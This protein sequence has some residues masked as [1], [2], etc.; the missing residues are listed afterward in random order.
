MEYNILA[1]NPGS[2]S[3]KAGWFRNLEPVKTIS[4]SHT[5]EEL[6]RHEGV[7]GQLEFRTQLILEALQEASLDVKS[8]DAVIGRGG[9][10]RP[11]ASGVYTV[12]QAM[13]E[14]LQAERH[15]R[16]ASNLG[17]LIARR[18]AVSAGV[19][20]YIAD[21]VVVD[22]LDEVARISGHPLL[23]RISIFHALNQKAMARRYAASVGR[24]YAELNLIVAHLG[25]GVSV[26][27]HRD[28]RVVDVN[29]ALDGEGPFSPERAGTLPWGRLAELCFSGEYT[30]PQ[31]QRMLCGQGGLVAHTGTN[32][33]RAILA[34]A[35]AGD[36]ESALLTEAFCYNV[37]KSIAALSALFSGRVDA[38]ILTG[39][40]AHSRQICQAIS[41]RVD[42]IAP[43]AILPGENEL[44]ALAENALRVLTG[45]ISPKHYAQS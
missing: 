15:G 4:L 30:Q 31:L 22:E 3:T 38:I 12:D 43:V 10:L 45:E 5:P 7:A 26:G 28:G 19:E 6:A 44:E 27:A 40:I 39:G 17:A 20:A 1:V 21:P 14:D 24:P 36:P 16:H 37:A 18:I 35:A 11:I 32:D 41:S 42:F 13:Q 34:Q 2:T 8:L 29:N 25:G 33:L 9:L 23:P